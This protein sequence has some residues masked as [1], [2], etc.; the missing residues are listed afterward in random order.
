MEVNISR[1][2]AQLFEP[3]VWNGL[4]KFQFFCHSSITTCGRVLLAVCVVV[5]SPP[6]CDWKKGNN[7]FVPSPTWARI[8]DIA[9]VI[10]FYRHRFPSRVHHVARRSSPHLRFGER[11]VTFV[12]LRRKSADRRAE[13]APPPRNRILPRRYGAW[14]DLANSP[15]VVRAQSWSKSTDRQVREPSARRNAE[16][17]TGTTRRPVLSTAAIA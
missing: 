5:F 12:H 11:V 2:D 9:Q 1:P 8:L 13:S 16:T 3:R 14:L 15:G 7:S 6:D 17:S 4:A 10:E